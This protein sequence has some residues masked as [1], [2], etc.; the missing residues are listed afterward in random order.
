MSVYLHEMQTAADMRQ[1][2]DLIVRCRQ[3]VEG[4]W[5]ELFTRHYDATCRF[6]FQQRPD[7][8]R[9]DVEEV[10]QEVFLS[11]VRN[12]DKFNG[13]S[14]LQTWIFRIAIN[15]ARDFSERQRAVKRG[16]GRAVASLDELPPDGG[17]P[18]EPACELPTPDQ[19]LASQEESRL[20][21]KALEQLG[22]TTGEVLRLR[23]FAGLSHEEIAAALGLNHKTV[24]TRICRGLRRLEEELRGLP[25]PRSFC[26]AAAD[27]F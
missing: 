27:G 17:R 21:C 15:R 4:A 16:G 6:L 19:A 7:F 20:L 25:I 10:A 9:E 23:Y 26:P 3:G 8:T 22:E 11:V 1:E 13:K 5:D 12:L 24:G 18:W 14:Q 2:A